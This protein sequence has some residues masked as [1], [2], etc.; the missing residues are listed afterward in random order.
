MIYFILT[1]EHRSVFY[2][3][4]F[5]SIVILPSSIVECIFLYE[6]VTN[7]LILMCNGKQ[8]GDKLFLLLLFYVLDLAGVVSCLH[9]YFCLSRK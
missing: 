7:G 5:M 1:R 4:A 3:L 9:I 8:G 6:F 2:I